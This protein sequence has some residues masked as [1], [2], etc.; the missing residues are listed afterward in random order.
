M[1]HA[2]ASSFIIQVDAGAGILHYNRGKIQE[3]QSIFFS[4]TT[5]Y[6]VLAIDYRDAYPAD[7]FILF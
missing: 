3:T 7:I 2:V 5:K 6:V 4:V 1:R